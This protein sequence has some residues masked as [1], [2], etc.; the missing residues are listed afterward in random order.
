MTCLLN[1]SPYEQTRYNT[2]Y[3][4]HPWQCPRCGWNAEEHE[5]RINGGLVTGSDGLKH[6]TKSK[7]VIHSDDRGN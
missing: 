2:E 5:R 3:P 7:A 4:C 1:R 6:F